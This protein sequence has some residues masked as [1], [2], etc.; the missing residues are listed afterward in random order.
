MKFVVIGS[1]TPHAYMRYM[2][3]VGG[4]GLKLYGIPSQKE[5]VLVLP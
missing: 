2:P 3:P 4:W 1:T 5:V